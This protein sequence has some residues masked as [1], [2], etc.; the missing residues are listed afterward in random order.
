MARYA[1]LYNH[2][3][4]QKEKWCGLRQMGRGSSSSLQAQTSAVAA[5]DFN[6]S[7]YISSSE[8]TEVCECKETAMKKQRTST[9]KTGVNRIGITAKF[10]LKLGCFIAAALLM[11]GYGDGFPPSALAHSMNPKL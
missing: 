1:D 5:V 9:N 2:L 11:F 4:E 3:L 8:Q 6:Y 10:K 7:Y